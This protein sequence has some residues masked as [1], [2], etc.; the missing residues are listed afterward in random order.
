MGQIH[1]IDNPMKTMKQID[2]IVANKKSLLSG[3]DKKK[4]T[5][6]STIAT[7]SDHKT[8][9]KAITTTGHATTTELKMRPTGG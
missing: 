8:M 2:H 1:R 9:D 5:I 6:D 3:K 7:T 4:E